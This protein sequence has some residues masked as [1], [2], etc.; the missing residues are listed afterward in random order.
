M[1]QDDDYSEFLFVSMKLKKALTWM[2][3]SLSITNRPRRATPSSLRTPYFSAISYKGL[4]CKQEG[5]I[6]IQTK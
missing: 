5:A 4:Q 2:V 3:P 6:N 1:R